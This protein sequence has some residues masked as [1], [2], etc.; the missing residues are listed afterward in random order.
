MF[1]DPTGDRAAQVRRVTLEK[2]QLLAVK[3]S[4]QPTAPRLQAQTAT[5]FIGSA[6]LSMSAG[7]TGE[8]ESL[9]NQAA[10]WCVIEASTVALPSI[11]MEIGDGSRHRQVLVRRSSLQC[12][13]GA[14]I[15]EVC[16]EIEQ[17]VLEICSGPEQ[18]AVQVLTS[19]RADQPF[20]KGMGQ[21]N[22]GDGFDLGHLQYP[23]RACHC[24]NR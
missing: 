10:H 20:H 12:S 9:E 19:N 6:V 15:V 17:L 18:R 14:M 21:G 11:G 24:P 23:E 8:Y 3:G 7:Y 22:V 4:D 13:M 5:G 2:Q 1:T 16:S